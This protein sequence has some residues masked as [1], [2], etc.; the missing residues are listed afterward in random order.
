MQKEKFWLLVSLK[1]SG[2]ATQEELDE[3]NDLLRQYPEMNLQLDILDKIWKEKHPGSSVNTNDAY[4]KHLQRLSNHLSRPAL[5]YELET[6]KREEDNGPGIKTTGWN[7][8]KRLYIWSGAAAA[9][10]IFFFILYHKGTPVGKINHPIAQNTVSTK[11][12]S[13]SKLQLPDGTQVWLNSD[14]KITYDEN[15]LGASREVQLTGEAYFDVAKDKEHPFIIHT[16]TIDLK[17]LGTAFNV[18]SYA[19]E[20]NTETS[21][22]HGSIEITLKNNPDKKIILKPDEK[23]IIRNNSFSLQQPRQ[24]AKA[25]GKDQPIMILD[26]IHFREKDSSATEVLWVKNRLAFDKESLESI[27]SKIERWFDVKIVIMDDKLKEA[28]YSAAFTDEGLHEVMEA[29][30]MTGNFRYTINKREIIIKP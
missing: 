4:N 8:R 13:K 3:L 24:D 22:I 12:G 7:F 30:R 20:K 21:L 18:R 15:F 1:L 17:V 14:S 28:E 29:L 5:E 16:Q 10:F 6:D 26:K 27:A 2:E 19:N 9:S 23:L 11:P 25:S